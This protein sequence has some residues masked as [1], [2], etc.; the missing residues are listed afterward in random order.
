MFRWREKESDARIWKLGISGYSSSNIISISSS[1][2]TLEK[3]IY[4]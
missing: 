4:M 3:I 2:F 1:F